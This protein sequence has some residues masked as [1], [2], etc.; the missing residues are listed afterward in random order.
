LVALDLRDLGADEACIERHLLRRA[1]HP[2]I[3]FDA[4]RWAWSSGD[5]N[6]RAV[7]GA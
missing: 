2:A 4:A 6:D 5:D 1:V 3:A 7:P